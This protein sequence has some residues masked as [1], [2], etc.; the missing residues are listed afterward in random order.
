M[1]SGAKKIS[2]SKLDF[3]ISTRIAELVVD[4]EDGAAAAAKEGQERPKVE[5]KK[6]SKFCIV[7]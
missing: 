7:L 5:K 6:K 4:E 2:R 3:P 1:E